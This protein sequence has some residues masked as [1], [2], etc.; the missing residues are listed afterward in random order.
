VSPTAISR[1][2]PLVP[3]EPGGI[4]QAAASVLV[5]MMVCTAAWWDVKEG[6]LPNAITVTGLAAAFILRAPLGVDSLLQGVGGFA[7]AFGVSAVLYALRAIGGGDVKLMAA[8]GAFL[9]SAEIMGALALI[10][11]LGAGYALLS[12]TWKG[13]LPLL[14]FN[15]LELVK[16]WLTLGRAGAIRK[17][18]S[19]S[20][21]SIPYGI[22]IALGT[23]FWW[24]GEGVSL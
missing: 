5:S 24:F 15:T 19:P 17:L 22:P 20:A 23:L 4:T 12:V 11:V 1:P 9:G 10:A 3:L 13:L 14:L 18:E 2:R 16:G 8:V 7:L 6:R 21:L